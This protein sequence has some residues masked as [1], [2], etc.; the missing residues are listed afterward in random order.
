M[1]AETRPS[2]A[3]GLA[4]ALGAFA[5]WGLSPLVY[6]ELAA[7]PPLEVLAH[8]TVWSLLFIGV[9]AVATKRMGRLVDA[10]STPRRALTL[11]GAALLISVNWFGFI[12]AVQVGR[13]MESSIGY[14]IYPLF[15]VL[16]GMIVFGERLNAWQWLAVGL[17]LT[18]VV[19]LTIGL[20]APP[21]IALALASTFA[22]YGLIK[23]QIS[24]GP[25]SSVL[26]EVL[27]FTPFALVWLA[28]VHLFGWSGIVDRP[29]AFF[30]GAVYESALLV[31]SGI[32]TGLPLVLFAQANKALAL[33]TVGILQYLNPSLQFAISAF[34]FLE[35]TSVWHWASM[36]LIW[37]ATG[38]YIAELLRSSRGQRS[39]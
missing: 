3:I 17:A 10:F 14:Y 2:A 39:A 5:I 9:F 11:V 22:L 19:T 38:L 25:I 24:T 33:S 16:L 26:G 13:A 31:F 15:A 12:Y 1:R 27:I 7:V 21:W 35:P 29:G 8:R 28:G 18:A 23:K 6:R 20:A 36:A 30:G 34:V 37:T 4:A 32:I